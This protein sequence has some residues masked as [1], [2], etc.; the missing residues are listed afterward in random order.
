MFDKNLLSGKRILVTGG[1]SGL[2]KE[3]SKHFLNHGAEVIICGRRDEV[4]QNTVKELT[5]ETKGKISSHSLD[6]RDSMAIEDTISNIFDYNDVKDVKHYK[7]KVGVEY[8]FSE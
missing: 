8:K 6:I 5:G 4:L 7:F 2:G 3:M 1:G